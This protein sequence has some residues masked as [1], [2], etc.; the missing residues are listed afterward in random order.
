MGTTAAHTT[1]ARRHN[2]P[3]ITRGV[4]AVPGCVKGKG[5]K[6]R[7]GF[8]SMHNLCR[9]YHNVCIPA[10]AGTR[11]PADSFDLWINQRYFGV[12]VGAKDGFLLLLTYFGYNHYQLDLNKQ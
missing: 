1:E 3:S 9:C 8:D 10:T 4:V 7:S 12:A 6:G 5:R 2:A 11:Q